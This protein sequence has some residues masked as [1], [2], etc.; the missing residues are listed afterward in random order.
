METLVILGIPGVL[1]NIL[2]IFVYIFTRNPKKESEEETVKYG[3]L[4]I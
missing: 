1:F 4:I 2:V 3:S